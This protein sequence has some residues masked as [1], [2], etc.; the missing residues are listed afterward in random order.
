[1]T[2]TCLFDFP[3]SMTA[4]TSSGEVTK[5]SVTPWGEGGGGGYE[6]GDTRGTC[7][8]HSSKATSN[9]GPYK[10]SHEGS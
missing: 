6:G 3:S 4:N 10:G 1:M 9:K 7:N 5:R 2:E 8:T